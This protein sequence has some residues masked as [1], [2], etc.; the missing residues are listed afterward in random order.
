MPV[1]PGAQRTHFSPCGR[2]AR[3]RGANSKKIQRNANLQWSREDSRRT[4]AAAKAGAPEVQSNPAEPAY[5]ALMPRHP[6]FIDAI[7]K[8]HEANRPM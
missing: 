5:L 4:N 1:Y 3:V 8:S 7:Q 2:R 6:V